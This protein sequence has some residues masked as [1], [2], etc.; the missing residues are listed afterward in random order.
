MAQSP[1]TAPKR[2]R[3]RNQMN[4]KTPA[5]ANLQDLEDQIEMPTTNILTEADT[6]FGAES[7]FIDEE[8]DADRSLQ[9]ARSSNS[10]AQLELNIIPGG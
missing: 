4:C 5:A 8:A 6:L 7:R 9:R 1:P 3:S 2:T 10:C